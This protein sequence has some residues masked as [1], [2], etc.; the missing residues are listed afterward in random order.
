MKGR[1]LS[2]GAKETGNDLQRVMKGVLACGFIVKGLF[3]VNTLRILCLP[4]QLLGGGTLDNI[5]T[6]VYIN[7]I[8]PRSFPCTFHAIGTN[9]LGCVG[10]GVPHQMSYKYG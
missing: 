6:S 2:P 9:N 3:V 8:L 4:G 1:P 7:N 10:E 5:V